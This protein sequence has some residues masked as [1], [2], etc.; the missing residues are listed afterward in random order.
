MNN[1]NVGS[2]I[3]SL[4]STTDL[5]KAANRIS[6]TVSLVRYALLGILA[7]HYSSGIMMGLLLFIGFIIAYFV[8]GIVL[9]QTSRLFF[10]KR[11]PIQREAYL[12][13]CVTVFPILATIALIV[14]TVAVFAK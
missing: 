12:M 6:G 10:L 5:M 4:N 1:D 9:C 7:W 11:H 3:E 14:Y 8:V 13:N 2:A